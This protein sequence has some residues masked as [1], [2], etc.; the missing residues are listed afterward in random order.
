MAAQVGGEQAW[1]FIVLR[2]RD[3]PSS[4]VSFFTVF[5]DKPAQLILE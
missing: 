2:C 1:H 4:R 3:R 5:T